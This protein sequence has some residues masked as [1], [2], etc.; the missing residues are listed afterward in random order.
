[1]LKNS[2]L[3]FFVKKQQGNNK[4]SRQLWLLRHG[5]SD[6]NLAVDDYDRPLK[7]RGK[8]AAERMGVWLKKENLIPDYLISSPAKRAYMTAKFVHKA[9][10]EETVDIVQDKRLY[11]EGFERLKTVLAECP[12]E[13]K[14]VLMVGHNPELEDLLVNLVGVNNLPDVERLLSTATLVRLTMPDD[15]TYLEAGCATLVGI[16]RAKLLPEENL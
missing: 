12:P 5:K 7:K 16:T 4:M 10:A 13:A 15:W 2:S 9:F 3:D 8:K 1:M 14:R 11:Q 6:R